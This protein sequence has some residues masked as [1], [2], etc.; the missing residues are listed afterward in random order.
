MNPQI[1][2][3]I[4]SPS[5]WESLPIGAVAVD[6]YGGMLCRTSYNRVDE[7]MAR[8]LPATLVWLPGQP[9]RPERVVKAEALRE[10][11]GAVYGDERAEGPHGHPLS[12]ATW[13]RERAARIES[14]EP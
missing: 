12:I 9:P 8:Y 4:T 10:A 11:A 14:G 13:L 3:V 1:G 7:H 6:E 2:D 5:E